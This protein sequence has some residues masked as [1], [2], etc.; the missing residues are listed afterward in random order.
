M[1]TQ[2]LAAMLVCERYH[3]RIR[4]LMMVVVRILYDAGDEDLICSWHALSCMLVRNLGVYAPVNQVF[5]IPFRNLV[6][7]SVKKLAD[8]NMYLHCGMKKIGYQ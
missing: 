3:L 2:A 1:E 5:P 6:Q 4:I 7:L 8:F